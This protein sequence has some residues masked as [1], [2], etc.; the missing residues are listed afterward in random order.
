MS[1]KTT[2]ESIHMMIKF[3]KIWSTTLVIKKMQIKSPMSLHY[4]E[5]KKKKSLWENS[6]LWSSP[7]HHR[8]E[9]VILE[10]ILVF[11][12]ERGW[13]FPLVRNAHKA[14]SCGAPVSKTTQSAPLHVPL[15]C[16]LWWTRWQVRWSMLLTFHIYDPWKTI[17]ICISKY[18][19]PQW[20]GGIP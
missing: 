6:I 2:K 1:T 7:G 12:W 10:T 18:K 4:K 8:W 14:C 17:C 15:F 16:L 9:Y 20:L 3:M 13:R 5:I 11:R 19:R